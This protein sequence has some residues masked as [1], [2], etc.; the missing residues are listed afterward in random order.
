MSTP[1]TKERT[2]KFRATMAAKKADRQAS[3]GE[4]NDPSTA[5]L[6]KLVKETK[7]K[8]R[9]KKKVQSIPLD[10]IPDVPKKPPRKP[11]YAKGH[12]NVITK[13]WAAME[14]VRLTMW[15]AGQK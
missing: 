15:L 13:E 9:R 14:I 3:N 1:W 10:A 7:A 4:D 6:T 12:P 5:A 11:S 8:K 2:E